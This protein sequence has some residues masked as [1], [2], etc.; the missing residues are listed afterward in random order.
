M[1]RCNIFSWILLS[2]TTCCT[3]TACV[4]AAVSGA[5]VA[6]NHSSIQS[7]IEDQYISTQANRRLYID[8]HDF[9]DTHIDIATYNHE[10]LMVGQVTTEQQR[11]NAEALVKKIPG[12]DRIYNLTEVTSTP[13]SSLKRVNDLWI[14]TKVRSQLVVM[15]EIDPSKIKV[16]TENGTVYLMGMV[17]PDQ[18][19]IAVDIARKTDGVEKV[20]RMFTYLNP[21]KSRTTNPVA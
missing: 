21:S 15:N 4:D 5:Q 11:K 9:D 17:L 19:D 16:V 3:L 20:I 1:H 7:N 14:T 12:V 6:Y 10:V 8:N 2:L 18:A 13:P